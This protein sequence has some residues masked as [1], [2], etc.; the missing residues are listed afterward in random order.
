MSPTPPAP[1]LI[2]EAPHLPPLLTGWRRLWTR[3]ALMPYVR[4]VVVLLAVNVGAVAVLLPGTSAGARLDP[5]LTAT[6][7]NLGVAAV[8]RQQHVVNLLFRL[9]TSAPLTWP[10]RVRVALAQVYHLGG[11]HVGAAV[12][13]TAWFCVF[14]ASALS[15]AGQRELSVP[16]LGVITALVLLLLAI[17]A[18]AAAPLR[19]RYH[20]LFETSHRFG[21]W[22]ALV[23]FAVLTVRYAGD[24]APGEPWAVLVSPATWVLGVVILSVA[25]P[26]LYLRKVVVDVH[27]P[28]SHVAIARLHH[29]SRTFV[30]SSTTIAR[31]PLGQWHPFAN[32][33]VPS[34]SS[35]R[36]AISR[37]GD[38]TGEFIADPPEHV[39][40]K[41]VPTAGVGNVDQLFR[42]VVWIAT[43][44]GIAPVLPNLLAGTAPAHLV[45]A[46]RSPHVTYG[47]E[48]V[49]EIMAAR[50]DA[51]VWDTQALGKPD[52]VALALDAVRTTGAEA[53]ICISNRPTT[54]EVV[55]AMESRGIPAFGAIWDS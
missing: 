15:P 5:T 24:R 10:L 7:L 1:T 50:P 22:L 9:A 45:W 32:I 17:A 54:F 41:G 27:T 40:V 19:R 48:L 4:L 18:L 36:M 44:S 39:W 13:A 23:L 29:R 38:W 2:P 6:A 25:L 37:A 12:A 43:G 26:W 33:V 52:L 11:I 34:E 46:T 55:E 35:F 31:H 16:T 21:G 47:P 53:V 28:S 8:I 42:R 49:A 14:A 3:P 20:D 30:G 51:L